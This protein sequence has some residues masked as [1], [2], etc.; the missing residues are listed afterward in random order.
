MVCMVCVYLCV[1]LYVRSS[2]SIYLLIDTLGC[3]HVLLTVN[4]AAMTIWVH[5]FFKLVLLFQLHTREWDFFF[6]DCYLEKIRTVKNKMNFE[7]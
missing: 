1:H 6:K 4:Y 7:L 3:S 2:F 5:V